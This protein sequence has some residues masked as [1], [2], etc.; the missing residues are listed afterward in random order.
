MEVDCPADAEDMFGENAGVFRVPEALAQPFHG[1]RAEL[2]GDEVGDFAVPLAFFR[3]LLQLLVEG[4]G[5]EQGG[6]DL[7]KITKPIPVVSHLSPLLKSR[8]VF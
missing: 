1:W 2:I 4:S 8:G 3:W 6:S 7:Q 5:D